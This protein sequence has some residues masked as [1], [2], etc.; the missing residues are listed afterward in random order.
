MIG[1]LASAVTAYAEATGTLRRS[2]ADSRGPWND[3]ARQAFDRQ[4][5]DPLGN[6]AKRTEAELRGLAEELVSAA[7]LLASSAYHEGKP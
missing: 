7:N 5:A 3:M 4:H 6:A 2:L 1:S